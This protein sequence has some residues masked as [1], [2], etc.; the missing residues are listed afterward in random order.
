MATYNIYKKRDGKDWKLVGNYFS[1]SFENAKIEFAKNCY[2]DLLNG[3]HGDNFVE[4][5]VEE[6]GVE[7]DGIYYEGELLFPKSNL[8]EGIESFSE[9]VYTWKITNSIEF[10]IYEADGTYFEEIFESMEQAKDFYPESEGYRVEY[11]V[12]KEIINF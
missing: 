5:S 3:K 8:I 6:D 11:K 10:V 12:K 7:V 2:N 1:D 4:L 9:D